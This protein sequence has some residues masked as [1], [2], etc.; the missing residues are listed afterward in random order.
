MQKV[1][2]LSNKAE[3][4][5]E[6]VDTTFDM[7]YKKVSDHAVWLVLIFLYPM[8]GCACWYLYC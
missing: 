2:Y 1:A 8:H 5:C 6:Y 3:K 7:L 4:R